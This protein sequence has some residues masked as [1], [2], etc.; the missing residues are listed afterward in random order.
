MNL[1]IRK[2]HPI[3]F[4]KEAVQLFFKM[5]HN[6]DKKCHLFWLRLPTIFV[7]LLKKANLS[8]T[9]MGNVGQEL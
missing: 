5:K 6:Y 7:L 3:K 2:K 9:R 1:L 8:I 4:T